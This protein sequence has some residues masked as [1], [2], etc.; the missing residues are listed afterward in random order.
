[1]VSCAPRTFRIE[2]GRKLDYAIIAGIVILGIV[3]VMT[4]SDQDAT[5][6]GAT[7]VA[8]AIQQQSAGVSP[9]TAGCAPR[10]IDRRIAVRKP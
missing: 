6:E 8:E 2:T 7:E 9:E 10:E 5:E 1:M 3:I 4:K